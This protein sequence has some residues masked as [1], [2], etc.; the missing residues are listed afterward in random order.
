MQE[1]RA[2]FLGREDAL[3]KEM[4]MHSN[5]LAWRI[6]G[7]E[8]PAGLQSMDSQRVGHNWVT[9]TAPWKQC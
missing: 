7:T 9:N 5:I 1:T 8:E 2:R 6:P 3:E 4:A